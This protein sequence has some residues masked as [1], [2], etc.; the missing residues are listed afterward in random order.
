MP[1]FGRAEHFAVAEKAIEDARAGRGGVLVVSGEPGIGKSALARTL[2]SEAEA[3]GA[4]VG[5]GR[6]WEVGGAPAYWP[7]SQALSDLGLD[8]DDLLGS[9]SGQ[10][11]SAQRVVA[12]DRVVRAVCP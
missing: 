7:W 6:A 10:M 12:F 9:T 8:L 3:R 2:A 11:A 4:R 5:F 1:L